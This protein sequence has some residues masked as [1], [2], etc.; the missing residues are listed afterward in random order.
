L[1]KFSEKFHFPRFPNLWI[2]RKK[3]FCQ[4]NLK[5]HIWILGLFSR[6]ERGI[7]WGKHWP[8]NYAYSVSFFVHQILSPRAL[9]AFVLS[10]RLLI[11]EILSPKA[12]EVRVLTPS[13]LNF[14]VLSPSAK[15]CFI[16][17]I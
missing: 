4:L 1:A 15:I 11:S 8:F 7:Y 12:F 9:A 10:P 3:I 14:I 2:F 6:D 13:A 16:I 17:E 5:D